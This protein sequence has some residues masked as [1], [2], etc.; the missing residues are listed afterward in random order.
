MRA[1]EAP[2]GRLPCLWM[3]AGLI[4]FRLCDREYD[5]DRCPLDAALRGGDGALRGG[6]ASD[7]GAQGALGAAAAGGFPDD[8]LYAPG[9]TWARRSG[10]EGSDRWRVGLDGFAAALLP[11][12]RA[13]RC[14]AAGTRLARGE[15]ACEVETEA[16]V[17]AISPPVEG[18]LV[19]GGPA[20]R[21]APEP[22][23]ADLAA[24][25]AD[26]YGAGWLFELAA[27]PQASE[28]GEL[29]DADE[30]R[31]RAGHD[32]RHF[33]RRVALSLLAANDGLGPTLPDGG[34]P[35]SDLRALLGPQAYL[36]LLRDLVH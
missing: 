17:V 13:L 35:I 25:V 19:A 10:G 26:P 4:S 21:A 31:R 1:T 28:A 3:T 8:R 33:R 18:R 11:P 7:P 34:Q 23:S 5:C 22:P 6:E 27:P 14:A 36:L 24:L 9:H 15:P 20:C 16:G 32:L 30:A 29:A 12:P 2:A